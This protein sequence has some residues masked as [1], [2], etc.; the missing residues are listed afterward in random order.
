MQ[1][2]DDC[3]GV[4]PKPNYRYGAEQTKRFGCGRRCFAFCESVQHMTSWINDRLVIDETQIASWKDGQPDGVGFVRYQEI[5]AAYIRDTLRSGFHPVYRC[6]FKRGI[7]AAFG[8]PNVK[9]P[10]S[11]D[12]YYIGLSIREGQDEKEEDEQDCGP[13]I[14]LPEDDETWV[15]HW[16][17]VRRNIMQLES[18]LDSD[19]CIFD[20]L[21]YDNN[22]NSS[23]IYV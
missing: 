15:Q 7:H 16:D 2:A 9:M 14:P 22:N 8:A 3:E 23:G 18:F 13:T 6:R 20:T 1:L 12:R 5:E 17:R 4:R 19:S 10:G 21:H 11:R